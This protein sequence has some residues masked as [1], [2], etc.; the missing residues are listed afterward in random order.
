MR[1]NR[2][3]PW[4][5]LRCL[6]LGALAVGVAHAAGGA[7]AQAELKKAAP[8]ATP[9]AILGRLSAPPKDAQESVQRCPKLWTDVA[10]EPV[11]KELEEALRTTGVAAPGAAYLDRKN[12]DKISEYESRW[13]SERQ[14]LDDELGRLQRKYD[15]DH[16]EDN[17]CVKSNDPYRCSQRINAEWNAVVLKA[18]DKFL[19]EA[20]LIWNDYSETV[21]IMLNENVAT[22]PP[23]A[24]VARGLPSIAGSPDERN[25]ASYDLVKKL[26]SKSDACFTA[27]YLDF[28]NKR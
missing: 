4:H 3:V 22:I 13:K 19:H 28:L 1:V 26:V 11:K 21:K 25:F 27:Q 10:V 20:R 24:S 5:S 6:I 2:S 15:P 7:N 8:V 23:R 12:W 16:A 14:K 18:V 17:P 9:R